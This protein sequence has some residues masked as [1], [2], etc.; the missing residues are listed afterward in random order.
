MYAQNE[1]RSK[2][3]PPLTAHRIFWENQNNPDIY[4]Y[5][6]TDEGPEVWVIREFLFQDL[7]DTV[8]K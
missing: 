6:P 4:E 3:W 5:D 7:V 1:Y 2:L 8:F